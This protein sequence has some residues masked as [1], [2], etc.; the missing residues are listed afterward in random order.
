MK[1]SF[2]YDKCIIFSDKI[3]FAKKSSKQT[4]KSVDPKRVGT[5][6]KVSIL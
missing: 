1:I 6:S 3:D 4:R 2:T 5:A